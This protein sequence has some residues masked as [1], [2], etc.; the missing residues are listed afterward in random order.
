MP[1]E[2]I[3][4]FHSCVEKLKKMTNF[5]LTVRVRLNDSG[6]AIHDLHSVW[7]IGWLARLPDFE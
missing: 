6:A 5:G 4:E 7:A 3:R 2:S 1:F